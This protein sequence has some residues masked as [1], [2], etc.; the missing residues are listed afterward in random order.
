MEGSAGAGALPGSEDDEESPRGLGAPHGQRRVEH[1]DGAELLDVANG[2]V[3]RQREGLPAFSLE[4]HPK[5][6]N[7][8]AMEGLDVGL[9]LG[10]DFVAEQR[11]LGAAE[12]LADGSEVVDEVEDVQERRA[13]ELG[14]VRNTQDP[15]HAALELVPARPLCNDELGADVREALFLRVLRRRRSEDLEAVGDRAVVR[16]EVRGDLKDVAEAGHQDV[17]RKGG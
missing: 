3:V 9:A 5:G 11:R 14:N 10:H 17:P 2:K 16:D 13:L 12:S 15:Q 6:L 7:G 8:L 1:L 4:H